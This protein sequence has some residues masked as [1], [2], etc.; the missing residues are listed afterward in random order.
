MVNTEK[1]SSLEYILRSENQC[2]ELFTATISSFK[3]MSWKRKSTEEIILLYSE[4]IETTFY[5]LFFQI[6]IFSNQKIE[7]N[8]ILVLSSVCFAHPGI[9]VRRKN[10]H[11]SILRDWNRARPKVQSC[12]T[13]VGCGFSI[14]DVFILLH[15]GFGLTSHRENTPHFD[16]FDAIN[17]GPSSKLINHKTKSKSIFFDLR[18][19]F[20]FLKKWQYWSFWRI[21]YLK[22]RRSRWPK[23]ITNGGL[24]KNCR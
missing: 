17:D 2:S 23:W 13:K 21:W 15:V 4:F 12:A 18:N 3:K 22:S 5:V 1:P 6:E 19:W 20:E 24:W 11:N 9:N 8:F 16:M 10:S 7:M 14:V